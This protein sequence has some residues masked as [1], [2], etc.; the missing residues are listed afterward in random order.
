MRV[1]AEDTKAC[2]NLAIPIFEFGVCSC[3]FL[4]HLSFVRI[5]VVPDR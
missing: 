5:K 1:F 4:G 3:G 2:I